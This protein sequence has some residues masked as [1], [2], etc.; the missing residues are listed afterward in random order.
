MEG[1]ENIS[2]Y[3]SDIENL[4]FEEGKFDFIVMNGVVEWLGEK[5]K[6]KD[7][8]D[9]Q[10]EDLRKV[11][12]LLKKGGTLYIGIENRFAATYLHN[13]KD[14]NRL[15]YTTFMPR[16]L[17]DWVTKGKLSKP[18]RTYTYGIGGYKKL[19]AETGFGKS[20][21]K[22]YVAHPGYNMP[23]YLID[24]EDNGAF[25]FFFSHTNSNAVF[26]WLLANFTFLVKR[27]FYS[28]VIFAKK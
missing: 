10:L 27:F 1:V 12:S 11:Y 19:L 17:A 8:R 4:P 26:K 6:N 20:E 13:A 24:F 7:P 9:D 3:H 25:R 5:N 28:Y 23:Q 2:L 16:F 21:L 15:R 18:Y 22:F 14:H